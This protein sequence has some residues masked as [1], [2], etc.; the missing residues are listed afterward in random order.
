MIIEF[1]LQNNND[2]LLENGY[3]VPSWFDDSKDR[4]LLDLLPF[5]EAL[6]GTMDVRSVLSLR[7]FNTS[8]TSGLRRIDH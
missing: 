5:L 3:L 6:N 7:M 8:L 4:V 2:I 1:F